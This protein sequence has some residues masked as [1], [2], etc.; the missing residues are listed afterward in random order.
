MTFFRLVRITLLTFAF[1][2][3]R[4]A[5]VRALVVRCRVDDRSERSV[6]RRQ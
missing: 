4:E 2:S 5:D 6:R 3:E 1:L